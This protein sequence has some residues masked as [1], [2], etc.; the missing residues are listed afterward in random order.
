M[1]VVSP[2]VLYMTSM[3][4]DPGSSLRGRL[5]CSQDNAPVSSFAA[6]ERRSVIS[7]SVDCSVAAAALPSWIMD[8]K[9]QRRT[10]RALIL[11]RRASFFQHG[12]E[13]H[14]GRPPSWRCPTSPC[15]RILCNEFSRRIRS[16]GCIRCRDTQFDDDKEILR[17]QCG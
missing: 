16:E 7:P 10:D 6:S 11:A 1:G 8:T 12:Y 3:G 5:Y 15:C 4:T 14:Q 17:W 2:A 13:I 9:Q